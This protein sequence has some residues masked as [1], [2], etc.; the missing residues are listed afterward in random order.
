MRTFNSVNTC[1]KCGCSEWPY[2]K[3]SPGFKCRYRYDSSHEWM[4]RECET[5]GY[6]WEE[7]CADTETRE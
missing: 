3:A 1:V 2:G 4:V 6:T 5:C 7:A